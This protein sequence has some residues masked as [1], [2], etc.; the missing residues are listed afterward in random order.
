MTENR[1][2][3]FPRILCRFGPGRLP[4][5]FSYSSLCILSVLVIFP[6][7]QLPLNEPNTAALADARV[8]KH[9]FGEC[10]KVK[11]G[12]MLEHSTLPLY[13]NILCSFYHLLILLS[14]RVKTVP[15]I[16]ESNPEFW[17]NITKSPTSC[18]TTDAAPS[19]PP[20]KTPCP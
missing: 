11:K 12:R 7:V 10:Y 17:D 4:V 14:L 5:L 16:S 2:S 1:E 6:S 19:F 9:E 15:R 20:G 18:V 8:R 13:A 3:S